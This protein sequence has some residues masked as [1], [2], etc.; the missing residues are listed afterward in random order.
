M[1]QLGWILYQAGVLLA[2]T[3]A[4]PYLLLRRRSHYWTSFKGRLGA[5]PAL[6]GTR[7]LWLH[8]VSVGEVGVAATLARALPATE[9]LLVTTVTP[10][11]Q[12][13]ARSSL[14]QRAGF[15]YLPLE[16]KAAVRRFL[17]RTSP[18]ALVLVEGD[19][20]PLLLAEVKRRRLPV[21]VVNG[22]ISDRTFRRL[23]RLARR[24]PRL[25]AWYFRPVDRFGLQTTADRDRL[26]ALG[27][28]AEK[29]IV[30]GNLKFET[31]EPKL[32]PALAERVALE[33]GGRPLLVA[34]STMAGE[35]AA[36]LD[37]FRELGG[38]RRALLALA[39]RHPERFEEAAHLAES[40]G[41]LVARRSA[42]AAT[43][44]AAS[45]IL[46][47]DTLGELAALYQLASVAFIGGTLVPTGGH[48]P[49]EAARYGVPVAVG[50]SMENFRE[51]AE[52]FD[53]AGAWSRV[54]DAAGLANVWRSWLD[55]P[56][57]AQALGARGAGLMAANRGALG[58]T[59]ELLAPLLEKN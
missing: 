2:L 48:N 4:G 53:Q 5:A 18:R 22:R 40:R 47:L 49:L 56:A 14:G 32:A 54:R 21:A 1:R 42:P 52:Q 30:T 20:W 35:E 44:G 19:Y 26:A 11:G 3:L 10:T 8:A 51:I 12:A 17:D 9:S 34:G 50:P 39:P 58:R 27:V 6:A 24:W 46:L 31:P 38:G 33:A 41:F 59:L 28:P 7:P 13:R 45:E 15:A 43:P 23:S 57:D 29:L 55:R 16:L 37:A 25:L 36:V